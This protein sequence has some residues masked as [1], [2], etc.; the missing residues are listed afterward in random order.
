MDSISKIK[1]IKHK[2][3][4]SLAYSVGLRVSEIVNLKINDIDSKRM[5]INIKQAKG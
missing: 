1:N 5:V 4:I 2:A 3:I